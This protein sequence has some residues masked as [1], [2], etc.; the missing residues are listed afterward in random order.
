MWVTEESAAR[1]NLKTGK[2]TSKD[3]NNVKED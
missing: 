1:E 3:K 2:K